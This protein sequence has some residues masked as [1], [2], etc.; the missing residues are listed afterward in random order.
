MR[1]T[2]ALDDNV[3][4]FNAPSSR[5]HVR[6]SAG[7]GRPS[8]PE[9]RREA[10]HPGVL[11]LGCVRDRIV[12]GASG[13]RG[14]EGSRL[15]R[16][17]FGS[18]SRARRWPAATA[19]RQADAAPIRRAARCGLT[20]AGRTVLKAM[21]Y[22]VDTR[23]GAGAVG[24]IVQSAREALSKAAEFLEEGHREVIFRDLLGNVLDRGVV[25]TMAEIED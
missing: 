23:S 16:R 1:P 17:H 12:P 8:E 11:G 6:A 19:W 15:D 25:V 10:S 4:D 21:P 3:F 24:V 14:A 7:R 18:A 5:H 13:S 20:E 9:S 2:T 22:H